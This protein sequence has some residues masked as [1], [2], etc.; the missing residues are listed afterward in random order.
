VKLPLGGPFRVDA[1]T[2]TTPLLVKGKYKVWMCYRYYKKSSSNKACVNQVSFDGTP[3]LRTFDSMAKRPSGTETD[4]ESQ[5][6]KQY[7]NETTDNNYNGRLL[8]IIDFPSTKTYQ[9]EVK[10]V[11]GSSSDVYV[12][13]VQFIPV[14]QNQIHP[15]VN[16]DGTLEQ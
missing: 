9:M 15:R 13:E 11:S 6:W 2:L 14:D 16:Q 1:F 8:G 7:L 12:D 5:G 3:M 10:W 4:L